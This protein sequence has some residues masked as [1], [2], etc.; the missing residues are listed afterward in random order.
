MSRMPIRKEPPGGYRP[1]MVPKALEMINGGKTMNEKQQAV[2]TN[3][4]QIVRLEEKK[5]V[6]VAVTSP[7]QKVTGIGETRQLFMEKKSG[8]QR[9]LKVDEY[10]CLHFSN[11]V[12]FTYIY[13]MEVSELKTIP[14]GMIGFTVPS[15]P[16]A[17]VR[18]K[19]TDPY[20]LIHT[21][22]RE[23]GLESN[24]NLFALEVF[25][26]GDEES[27]YNADILVPIMSW[28]KSVEVR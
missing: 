17:K 28:N 24:L 23:N 1:V 14:D 9:I 27:K 11:E 4:V 18:S 3:H 16:Y 6:G 8:I 22:L 7:F 15:S 13:C 21:Y 10:V 25:R 19:D 26:F 20:E 12:V 5:F 2:N